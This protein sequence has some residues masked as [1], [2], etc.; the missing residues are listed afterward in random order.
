MI[1]AWPEWRISMVYEIMVHFPPDVIKNV[2]RLFKGAEM[3]AL[4]LKDGTLQVGE[5]NGGGRYLYSLQ[6]YG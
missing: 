2:R 6:L 4:L 5:L 1:A 3:H